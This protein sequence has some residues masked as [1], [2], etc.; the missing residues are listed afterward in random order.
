MRTKPPQPNRSRRPNKESTVFGRATTPGLSEAESLRRDDGSGQT[1]IRDVASRPRIRRLADL[2]SA[3]PI[4]RRPQR[5]FRTEAS[6]R[7]SDDAIGID[8]R[9]P[10]TEARIERPSHARCASFG[11]LESAVARRA[12]VGG[13]AQ[14]GYKL[15]GCEPRPRSSVAE[16]TQ[17]GE[18]QPRLS[19]EGI[20]FSLWSFGLGSAERVRRVQPVRQANFAAAH[21]GARRGLCDCAWRP[22]RE[23]GRGE[24]RSRGSDRLRSDHLS[25]PCRRRVLARAKQP[26]RLRLHLCLLRRLPDADGGAA[27]AAAQDDRRAAIRRATPGV[28]VGRR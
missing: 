6:A 3:H 24:R 17:R 26:D 11:G 8:F 10:V 7:R 18:N 4:R 13:S 20:R 1:A 15:G 2:S 28:A 27:A 12:S 14:P 21:R 16:M 19:G 22:V 23:P 9:R 25:Q 5:R